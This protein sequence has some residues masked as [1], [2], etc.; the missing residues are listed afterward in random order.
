[1]FDEVNDE[2]LFGSVFTTKREH[3]RSEGSTELLIASDFVSASLLFSCC[4][5]GGHF[6]NSFRFTCRS[7]FHEVGDVGLVCKFGFLR[8][9]LRQ[10]E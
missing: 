5:S 1:M 10:K 9:R 4:I 2:P 8:G 3:K 6:W 7:D